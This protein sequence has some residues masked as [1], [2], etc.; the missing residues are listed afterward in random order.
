MDKNFATQVMVAH[1]ATIGG[2]RI[3]LGGRVEYEAALLAIQQ[4]RRRLG[5][6]AKPFGRSMRLMERL[7]RSG[8]TRLV[9]PSGNT[10]GRVEKVDRLHNMACKQG[11]LSFH[12]L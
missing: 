10:F 5:H 9:G 4:S 2:D 12:I 11:V 3:R 7:P 6:C 1:P 8:R